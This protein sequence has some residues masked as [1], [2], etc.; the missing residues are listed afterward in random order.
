MKAKILVTIFVSMLITSGYSNVLTEEE[1]I[2]IPLTLYMVNKQ[3]QTGGNP[4]SQDL[5]VSILGHVLY[6]YGVSE[7][8][9]L[10][11]YDGNGVPVFT[12]CVNPATAQ[13]D[14]PSSLAGNYELRLET[15][16]MYY[17]GYVNL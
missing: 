1:P 5:E 9:T 4:K 12:D 7:E 13:L 6:L 14:L 8:F 10:S 17:V 2:D 15:D 11:L 3:K 16:D